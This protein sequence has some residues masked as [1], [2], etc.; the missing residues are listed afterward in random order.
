MS[1]QKL[2][3]QSKARDSRS[4]DDEWPVA[5]FEHYML[6]DD[7]TAYSLTCYFR[8]EFAGVFRRE[9]FQK[10]LAAALERHPFFRVVLCGTPRSTTQRMVWR[11]P[12]SRQEPTIHW[13]PV[14]ESVMTPAAGERLDIQAGCGLHLWLR[15]ENQHTS[16]LLQVHHALCDAMGIFSFMEDLLTAYDHLCR[17]SAP[18]MKPMEPPRL[19][20]RLS[21]GLHPGER[22]RRLGRDMYGALRYFSFRPRPLATPRAGSEETTSNPGLFCLQRHVFPQEFLERLRALSRDQQATVNDLLLRDLFLA[23]DRWNHR[24][25]GVS[26]NLRITM[27]TDLRQPGDESMP[28]ANLLGYVFLDQRPRHLRDPASLL[29][30][31]VAQTSYAKR[32]RMGVGLLLALELMGRVPGL[33]AGYMARA[34][35]Q[36]SAVLTNLGRPFA[37]S[38][39]MGADGRVRAGNMTL[40]GMDTIP[41]IRE[42]TLIAISV[43]YYANALSLTMRYDSTVLSAWAAADLL[44]DYV[45]RLA[46]TVHE[47]QT[48]GAGKEEQAHAW[49]GA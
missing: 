7:L 37:K 48:E 15:E 5:A 1:M 26:R 11:M 44:G 45:S 2:Q 17:A 4:P 6:A 24:Q 21:L 14:T 39:L 46:A 18:V 29:K 38:P 43:N 49:R 19:G 30:R 27:P 40:M 28:A 42:G 31:V 9:E 10:A 25:A 16:L 32:N 12:P 22:W 3:T 23:L 47:R 35:C 8:F 20:Q 13:V 36:S 33:L 41:P 34:S